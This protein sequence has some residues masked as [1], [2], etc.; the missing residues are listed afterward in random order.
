M[1]MRMRV[2]TK[3]GGEAGEAGRRWEGGGPD[4][5][6]HR[7]NAGG[8]QQQQWNTGRPQGKPC[9]RRT[10]CCPLASHL[11][12]LPPHPPTHPPLLYSPHP[13]PLRPTPSPCCRQ[14]LAADGNG[15]GRGADGHCVPQHHP[16][17]PRGVPERRAAA[18][19]G[20]GCLRSSGGRVVKRRQRRHHAH[21]NGQHWW[22][23]PPEWGGGGGVWC[24]VVLWRGALGGGA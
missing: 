2:S 21:G 14:H 10:A 17:P 16:P 1:R 23:A 3:G 15:G 12:V 5:A 7:A 19:R 18:R 6:G 4:E 22:G 20:P 24:G 9:Q 13:H 11:M 8:V